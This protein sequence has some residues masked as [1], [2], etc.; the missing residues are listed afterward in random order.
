MQTLYILNDNE[1]I[2]ETLKPI[3]FQRTQELNGMD[4]I[5]F[6]AEQKPE[7]FHRVVWK[8]RFG[9]WHEYIVAGVT[10]EHTS[11]GI[12]NT[13]YCE[14]SV[15]ELKG[16]WVS[17]V[18]TGNVNGNARTALTGI[19][20]GV[21]NGRTR[22]RWSVGTVDNSPIVETSFYRLSAYD[23]LKE[24]L[25]KWKMEFETEITVSGTAIT[26]RQIHLRTLLGRDTG[27]RYTWTKDLVDI[28]RD[29]QRGD[30]IT[31]LIG[32]G[33]GEAIGDGYG[34]RITFADVNGGL[35]YI[36]DE[37]ARARWGRLNPD[38]SRAHFFGTVEFDDI[39]DKLLLKQRTEEELP[40][41]SRPKVEYRANVEDLTRAGWDHE[42]VGIGDRVVII[43]E[44]L[45]IRIKA[46]VV[47]LKED[48]EGYTTEVT[49]GDLHPTN[50]AI[51]AQQNRLLTQ[52]RSKVNVWDRIG[53]FNPDGTINADQVR[54]L[55][56]Q[57]N[58]EMNAGNLIGEVT[59]FSGG[60]MF[61]NHDDSYAV[62]IGVR[63]IRLANSK[64]PD[65]SW[66]FTAFL[67]GNGLA[68]NSVGALQLQAGSV[69]TDH[70]WTEGLDASVIN[71]RDGTRL[72]QAF[73]DLAQETV[74]IITEQYYSST[75]PTTR[76]G[77]QWQ[78]T[79]PDWV[80]G[81]YIWAQTII[82]KVDGTQITMEPVNIT[83]AIGASG[84]VGPPGTDGVGISAYD[85]E[86]SLS[87]SGST[88]PT[89][90]WSTTP[91]QWQPNSYVWQRV[92]VT[93]TNGRIVY[94]GHEA[95]HSN[96]LNELPT[97][98]VGIPK[99]PYR[100][101]DTW[102][103]PP[104]TWAEVEA[105]GQTWDQI[106]ATGLTWDDISGGNAYI[107]NVT[108]L[109]GAF[110]RS[111]WIK[112]SDDNSE[113][114]G[115]TKRVTD[116]ENNIT[117]LGV[118]LTS[119]TRLVGAYGQTLAVID[120]RMTD[121]EAGKIQVSSATPSIKDDWQINEVS[122]VTPKGFYTEHVETGSYSE[123]SAFGLLHYDGI[124]KRKYFHRMTV[125]PFSGN[126]TTA[127]KR[128]L[129]AHLM[130]KIPGQDFSAVVV[131][132]ESG[133]APSESQAQYYM[134]RYYTGFAPPAT[135]PDGGESV[136]STHVW[137]MAYT[138]WVNL[139]DNIKTY[140]GMS[141]ATGYVVFYS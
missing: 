81:R 78:S 129:P 58:A 131:G 38:G 60:F 7:K 90:G 9:K 16:D 108:R 139:R 135:I 43:D 4:V 19:L 47:E 100:K 54:D 13:Y 99:P 6:T 2:V 26:A 116:S 97:Q 87:E 141:P 76:E 33:R 40:N 109:E 137:V 102:I 86:Y 77:G 101:G 12:V 21:E 132:G 124:T 53:S 117:S 1:V 49:V 34:R 50:G 30:V 120:R 103:N 84:Q 28:E 5:E 46:R 80:N 127:I 113:I 61:E 62:E 25:D 51:I 66:N 91:P 35:D 75:S 71:M 138:Y 15:M 64:Y 69:Q 133:Q 74:S 22:T 128:D 118:N 29:V 48:V 96:A 32:L 17:E 93:Y 45:G 3:T 55:M 59:A 114:P 31:A 111:D 37:D 104:R 73:L 10:N 110:L 126:G 52:W 119:T 27:K 134:H 121:V 39:E 42:G 92:K 89:S 82:T 85:I 56:A 41:R 83:G 44:D 63:G 94:V 14:S 115:L 67:N 136:T 79:P 123:L 125:M 65:G 23:A 70:V 95:I 68:A 24:L 112:Y 88:V 107:C 140:D 8:D 130:G 72:D 122:T 105:W 20:T 98:H 18:R 11:R 106:Y 57:V 36:A